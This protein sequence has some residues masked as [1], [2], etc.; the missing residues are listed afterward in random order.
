MREIPKGWTRKDWDNLDPLQQQ[1]I[2][3]RTRKDDRYEDP[4][5]ETLASLNGGI[6]SP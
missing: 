4:G 5:Y 1:E 2:L 6:W 3:A